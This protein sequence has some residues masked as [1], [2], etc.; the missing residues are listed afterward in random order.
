[1]AT[2]YM[3]LTLPTVDGSVDTW[4][5]EL[6]TLLEDLVDPHDHTSG[7]GARIP[8]AG[9]DIDANISIATYNLTSVGGLAFASSP[10][11]APTSLGLY[12]ASNEL[13]WVTS[14]GTTVQLTNGAALNTS[15]LGG[16][17]GDYTSTDAD[18]EYVDAEKAYEFKQDEGPDHWANLK[19]GN[20]YVFEPTSGITN[21]V[22]L[23]SPTSLASAYDITL[24]AALPAATEL[25]TMTSA[26]VLDHTA[27][28]SLTTLS[29]TGDIT[30]SAGDITATAGDIT[31]TA[32]DLVAGGNVA[33][34]GQIYHGEVERELP[35]LFDEH[36]GTGWVATT[37]GGAAEYQG[38]FRIVIRIPLAEEEHL[39][40][41]H[42]WVADNTGAGNVAMS[43]WSAAYSA[44][45]AVPT[46][47]Q[48]GSTQT[49]DDVSGTN[50]QQLSVTG[51]DQAYAAQTSLSVLVRGSV[52]DTSLKLFRATYVYDRPAP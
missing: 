19:V 4:G 16:I 8:S 1:M 22:G 37:T 30:T 28:P 50:V 36:G 23:K 26:G 18:V 51:L 45:G 52:A 3:G 32:G 25:L 2:T 9:L 47:T 40:E 12:I 13:I 46:P 34:T 31:A 48:L 14:G 38:D 29:A 21:A 39:K 41:V 35:I 43:V 11:V 24:P 42:V 27:T 7:K 17:T 33:A 10:A 49:T 44:G 5:T 6:N 20:V 15:L